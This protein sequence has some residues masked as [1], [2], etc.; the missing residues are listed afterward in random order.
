MERQFT[1]V[2]DGVDVGPIILE[3][4]VVLP[5]DSEKVKNSSLQQIG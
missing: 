1:Y 5:V 2:V 4:S 3:K